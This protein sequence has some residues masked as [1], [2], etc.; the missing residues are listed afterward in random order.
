MPDPRS[1]PPSELLPLKLALFGAGAVFGI[2]GM[3]TRKDLFV[4]IGIA[5]LALGIVVRML[6]G[7]QRRERERLQAL[8]EASDESD[9]VRADPHT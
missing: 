9:T 7:R 8:A 3:V 5:F 6:E 1:W 4:S 2:A